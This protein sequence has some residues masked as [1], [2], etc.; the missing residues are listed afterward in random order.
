MPKVFRYLEGTASLTIRF[1]G[2]TILVVVYADESQGVYPDGKGRYST[3]VMVGAD[4]VIRTTH[5]MKCITL[6]WTE[7]KIVGALDAATYFRW[8]IRIFQEYRLSIELPIE[9]RQDSLS[10]MHIILNGLNFRRA[11]H[12]IIKGE[13]IKELEQKGIAK[14]L[15]TETGEMNADAYTKPYT[16]RQLAKY[17]GRFFI[18]LEE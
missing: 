3:V 14:M 12:M 17:T 6:S 15:Y 11:K 2:T 5:K 16:G 18:K 13:F 10:A 4:E 9:P 8:L 1:I 7:S